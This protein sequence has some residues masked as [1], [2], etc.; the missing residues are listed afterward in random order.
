MA[1]ADEPVVIP[2]DEKQEEDWPEVGPQN[3]EEAQKYIEQVN[4]IFDR[5]MEML[6]DDRKDAIMKMVHSFRKLMGRYWTSISD[7]DPEVIIRVMGDPAG[8][9]LRQH[10]TLEGL[11]VIE[12]EME[13][14]EGWDFIRNLPEKTRCKEEIDLIVNT[15][16]HASEAH[17]H[18]SNMCTNLSSLVKITDRE[19]FQTVLKATI[20]SLVQINVPECF[21]N[22]MENLKPQTTAEKQ[23]EKVCRTILLKH[24]MAVM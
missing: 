6:E 18:M 15:M 24:N 23:M 14:E 8:V 3:P 16:D 4:E 5:L 12:P 20:R 21:L 7:T 22:P 11:Q 19:M 10:L 13:M 2:D 9:Y 1:A 17:A